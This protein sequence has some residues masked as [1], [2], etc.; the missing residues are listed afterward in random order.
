VFLRVVKKRHGN[1]VYDYAQIAEHYRENG[2][3]KNRVLEHLGPVHNQDDMDR[4]RKIFEKRLEIEKNSRITPEE[5]SILPVMEFGTVY[6]AMHVIRSTGMY[7][8]LS[9]IGKY[10][11]IAALMIVARIIEPSSDI[12]LIGLSKRI[13]YPWWKIS[14]SKDAI[15]R[16]LDAL[17]KSK[18]D[19]ELAIFHALKPDTSIVHYDLF[20]P[21]LLVPG[22]SK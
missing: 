14:I 11:D 18:D 17:I 21:P 20:L 15:Y 5:L 2:K 9:S 4:Y 13:Y 22:I 3:Q 19:I 16:C 7:R 10:R 8:S 6:A 12:S 1:R